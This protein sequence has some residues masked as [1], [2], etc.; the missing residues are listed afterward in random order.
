MPIAKKIEDSLMRA[1]VLSF[2]LGSLCGGLMVFFVFNPLSGDKL[3]PSRAGRELSA[4]IESIP[5][6]KICESISTGKQILGDDHITIGSDQKRYTVVGWRVEGSAI[7]TFYWASG[8]MPSEIPGCG[9]SAAKDH[10]RVG[11]PP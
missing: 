2:F 3:L 11:T 7:P 1:K 4:R 10:Q 6:D 9:K 5:I 8:D